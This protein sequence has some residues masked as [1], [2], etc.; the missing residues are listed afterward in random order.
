MMSD[1]PDPFLLGQRGFRC[2]QASST[3]DAAFDKVAGSG[4]ERGVQ[5]R[6]V[7]EQPL[8]KSRPGLLQ[9]PPVV[10]RAKPPV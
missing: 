7:F 6:H 5:H 1:F 8:T 10:S 2:F 3:A 9:L 4:R